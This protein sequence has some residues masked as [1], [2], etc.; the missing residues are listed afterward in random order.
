ML[1]FVGMAQMKAKMMD[2]DDQM[3]EKIKR[4]SGPSSWRRGPSVVR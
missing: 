3:M 2:S 1:D 4:P